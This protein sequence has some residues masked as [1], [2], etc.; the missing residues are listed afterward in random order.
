MNHIRQTR[1]SA[2][3]LTLVAALLVS[4]PACVS[5]ERFEAASTEVTNQDLAIKKLKDEIT[6]LERLNADYLSKSE[7][8]EVEITKL[9]R[10]AS[11]AGEVDRLKGELAQLRQQLNELGKGGSDFNFVETAR[12]PVVRLEGN[13]IFK[14]AR[15]ELTDRGQTAL[16][17]VAERLKGTDTEITVEGHT[18]NVPVVKQRGRYPLGNLELSGRRAMEVANFLIEKG[19]LSRDR[20]AFAGFGAERPVADNATAEGREKNRRVDILIRETP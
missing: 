12:G 8:L 3:A 11:S 2:L 9:R 13:L 19:G 18:D 20:V 7:L 5:N 17:E 6:R 1:R 15:H 10:Q 14:S 4:L 16:L